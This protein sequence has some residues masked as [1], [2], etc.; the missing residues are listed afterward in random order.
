MHADWND[1]KQLFIVGPGYWIATQSIMACDRA[2]GAYPMNVKVM[3]C[4]V[5]ALVAATASVAQAATVRSVAGVVLVSLGGAYQRLQGS[6]QLAAGSSVIANPGGRGQVVYSETCV[7]DVLP[8]AVV[9]IEASAPCQ[10]GA[11]NSSPP[12]PGAEAAVAGGLGTTGTLAIVG[13]VAILG[14]ALA[15]GGGGGDDNNK[16]PPASP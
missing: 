15:L 7:V 14:G 10:A 3:V 2:V 16:R 1:A 11:Q 4:A 6:A 9:W 5:A 8:G 13:G 12:A